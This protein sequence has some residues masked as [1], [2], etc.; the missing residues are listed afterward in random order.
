MYFK[1]IILTFISVLFPSIN[2]INLIDDGL[3]HKY[4]KLLKELTELEDD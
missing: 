2:M 4:K 1:V 3:R